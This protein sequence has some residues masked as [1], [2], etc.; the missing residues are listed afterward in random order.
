MR[1]LRDL[2]SALALVVLTSL[3]LW[4]AAL[5]ARQEFPDPQVLEPI[6]VRQWLT[7]RDL[8][9]AS[10]SDRSRLIRRLEEQVR[11]GE[12]L[13]EGKKLNSDE[14]SRLQE[15][16]MPLLEQWFHDKAHAYAEQPADRREEWMDREVGQLERLIPRGKGEK[17]SAL[18]L[19]QSLY[20]IGLIGSQ[21]EQWISAAD[22]QTQP[23]LREFQQALTK[24]LLARPRGN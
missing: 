1:R 17:S 20:A 3:S 22:S 21:M 4:G 24:R 15:N 2:L 11:S 23:R 16:L 12:R 5:V 13:S 14:Q 10:P 8:A 9:Q 7:Q 19:P 18:K 6:D